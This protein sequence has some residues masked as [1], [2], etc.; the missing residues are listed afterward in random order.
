LT[1]FSIQHLNLLSIFTFR[2]LWVPFV[3]NFLF[4]FFLNVQWLRL[5]NLFSYDVMNLNGLWYILEWFFTRCILDKVLF[6]DLC[7]SYHLFGEVLTFVGFD[8]QYCYL[9]VRVTI[10][11]RLFSH[12]FLYSHFFCWNVLYKCTS[13]F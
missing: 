13:I 5:Q 6:V 12:L 10:S 4:D 2:N 1:K 9:L 8:R 3:S 11:R 7:I